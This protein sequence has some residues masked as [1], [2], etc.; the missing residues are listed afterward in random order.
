M[1][2]KVFYRDVR[3]RGVFDP[4]HMIVSAVI[5]VTPEYALKYWAWVVRANDPITLRFCS[6]MFK[7]EGL[8]LRDK[9][10]IPWEQIVKMV[11]IDEAEAKD[12]GYRG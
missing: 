4:D 3:E 7:N 1:T 2:I 10:F 12:L 8:F 11:A 9:E 5:N 6:Y